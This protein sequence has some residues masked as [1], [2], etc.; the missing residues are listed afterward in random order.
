MRHTGYSDP[1]TNLLDDLDARLAAL[2]AGEALVPIVPFRPGPVDVRL[3]SHDPSWRASAAG[4]AALAALGATDE[5]LGVRF[6]DAELARLGSALERGGPDSLATRAVARGRRWVVNF[7]DPNT[8]KALH[9]GHLRNVAI[10]NALASAVDTLGADVV[11]QSR[12]G[13]F[14]RSMGE[15]M[16][17]Y[18]EHGDGRTPASP[19]GRARRAIG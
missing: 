15:A 11:R 5:P 7:G 8:T 9:V 4:R 19:G 3:E 2:G 12:V 14:G 17:G 10:G 18:I 16:A 13:D 1:S 6:A